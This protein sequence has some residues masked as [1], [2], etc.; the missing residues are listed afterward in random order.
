M[1]AKRIT[2]CKLRPVLLQVSLSP[3]LGFRSAFGN[4][5]FHLISQSTTQGLKKRGNE[6]FKY[7]KCSLG[8]NVRKLKQMIT[9]ADQ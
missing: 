6:I 1:D 7:E 8:K 2:D 9:L 4:A 3:P 5:L